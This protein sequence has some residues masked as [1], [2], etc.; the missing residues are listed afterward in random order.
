MDF[1]IEKT[2]VKQCETVFEGKCEQSIDTEISLPEYCGDIQRILKCCSQINVRSSQLTGG[3]FVVEGDAVLRLLYV[4]DDEKT[5]CFEQVIPL[6]CYQD[7]NAPDGSFCV[8]VSPSV[9]YLNCRALS[10]RRASVN[11]KVCIKYALL[12]TTEKDVVCE[13]KGD[14]IQTKNAVMP[15]QILNGMA[16]RTFEMTETIS[17]EDNELSV[18]AIVSTD[19]CIVPSSI[20]AISGKVL[21]KGDLL[22]DT[23]YFADTDKRELVCKKHSMPV[24]QIIEIGG[25]DDTCLCISDAKNISVSVTAKP[26]S[27]GAK[28]L[29]DY[30]CRNT[31]IVKAYS[32]TEL[33]V[34]TDSYCVQG[35]M[36][37]DYQL[38]DFVTAVHTKDEEK[39]VRAGVDIAIGASGEVLQAFCQSVA[40]QSMKTDESRTECRVTAVVGVCYTDADDKKCYAEKTLDFDVVHDISKSNGSLNCLPRFAVKEVS[41]SKLGGDKVEI[42]L[43]LNVTSTVYDK[44]TQSVCT[45]MRLEDG[46]NSNSGGKVTLYFCDGGENVWEIAK[47]YKSKINDIKTENALDGETVPDKRMLVIPS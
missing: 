31:V 44:L 16:E 9:E 2:T 30:V 6:S 10:Q 17:L 47:K 26:D 34:L 28:R 41:A 5:D 20:K 29:L 22:I 12:Q 23:V 27:A 24:S 42:R 39:V 21:F 45:Q 25:A 43:T 40:V 8:D 46:T 3:R 38:F 7:V 32:P 1:G 13:T 19:A 36:A 37:A 15:L 4:S 11:G 33:N 18:G 35:E 14:C